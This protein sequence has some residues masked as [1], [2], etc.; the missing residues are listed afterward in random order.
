MKIYFRPR[1]T[2]VASRIVSD[3][4]VPNDAP[5]SNTAYTFLYKGVATGYSAYLASPPPFPATPLSVNLSRSK[6]RNNSSLLSCLDCVLCSPIQSSPVQD[7]VQSRIQSSFI[8]SNLVD[9]V[10]SLPVSF[11][12]TVEKEFRFRSESVRTAS[13]WGQNGSKGMSTLVQ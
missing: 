11:T 2:A 5:T 12:T 9:D 1:L 10:M 3:L 13:I 6:W 4:K 7:S 8:F